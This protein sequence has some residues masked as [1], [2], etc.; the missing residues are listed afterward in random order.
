MVE[1]LLHLPVQL[2]VL[3][4]AQENLG[5]QT[6]EPGQGLWV[7]GLEVVLAREQQVVHGPEAP[8]LR[9]GLGS[10]RGPFG[11]RMERGH[12]EVAVHEAQLGTQGVSHASQDRVRFA[13]M[14]ALE[15]PVL[16]QGDPGAGSAQAVVLSADRGHKPRGALGRAHA[17][18][19]PA[20]EACGR[21]R[22]SRARK[23]PS[24]PGLTRIGE[25]WAQRMTP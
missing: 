11:Q 3:H 4:A 1:I 10:H 2:L 19:P 8:F 5:V 15:I 18:A 20:G 14:R 22:A 12:G 7:Q 17:L 13:T 21:I 23:M 24:A 6:H 9:G 25:R 16:D